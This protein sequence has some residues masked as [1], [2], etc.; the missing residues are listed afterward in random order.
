MSENKLEKEAIQFR[1]N[2]KEYQKIVQDIWSKRREHLKAEEIEELIV[3]K[4]TPLREKLIEEF[5]QL[6]LYFRKIGIT[7]NGSMY[8]RVFPVFDTA[9]DEK[10]FGNPG[11]GESLSMSIQMAIKAVGI[12][13]AM[14]EREIRRL[15]KEM[16]IIFISYNFN[17]KNKEIMGKFVDF[18]S[19]FNVA[20]SRGSEADTISISEKVKNKID[21]A[22]IVIAIM[23]KDEQN[24]QGSWFPSKWII[25]ELA[26][27]LAN[28]NKEII[29][30]LEKDCDTNGRIFGDKEY[31]SFERKNP[32]EAFIKLAEILNKKVNKIN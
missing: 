9:L 14:D 31:I 11:K 20:I 23:T 17:K 32:S 29:R 13:K 25:E 3:T 16:P 28:K 12:I 6:E 26:Y 4:E 24:E 8:G 2:L 5:G 7:M 19:N 18:I 30:I 27:A 10:L 22:D 21:D 1:D 15:K